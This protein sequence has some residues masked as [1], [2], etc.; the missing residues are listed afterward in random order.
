[1]AG[2]TATGSTLASSG[3]TVKDGTD[4]A[5]VT[6]TGFNAGSGNTLT[7]TG[8]AASKA[9][10][11]G[12]LTVGTSDNKTTVSGNTITTGTVNASTL[13]LGTGNAWGSTGITATAATISG[14]GITS[15]GLDLNQ[16]KI[17]DIQSGS[18]A[19][20]STDAVSGGAVWSEL[21]NYTTTA[22]SGWTAKVGETT[23]RVA[24]GGALTYATDD[25]LSA[26]LS[27][28]GTLTISTSANPSYTTVSAANSVTVGDTAS[29]TQ[30]TGSGVTS[31]SF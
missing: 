3:L 29:N 8:L 31:E 7:N 26:A 4:T 20:N 24:P 23:Y 27:S 25:N 22:N 2:T 5:T 12:Q 16:Q 9:D 15:T 17:T 30:I 19:Q 6:P 11:A 21:Q 1:M 13:S 14:I 28:T 10:I 18:I